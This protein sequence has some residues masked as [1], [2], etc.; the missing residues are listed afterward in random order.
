MY[1]NNHNKK[2]QIERDKAAAS[3]VETIRNKNPSTGMLYKSTVASRRQRSD[4]K[5][6]GKCFRWDVF[7]PSLRLKA[8]PWLLLNCF[9]VVAAVE[10][11]SVFLRRLKLYIFQVV[12]LVRAEWCDSLKAF[13]TKW[14]GKC[15]A[16]CKMLPVFVRRMC[17]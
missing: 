7:L 17:M 3:S 13:V 12:V 6:Y 8:F 2:L 10:V 14:T 11:W 9:T 1:A 4:Y 16:T 5:I 15:A